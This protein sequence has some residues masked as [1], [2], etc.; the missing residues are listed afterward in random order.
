[1]SLVVGFRVR[2]ATVEDAA[3]NTAHRRA[4]FREMRPAGDAVLDEMAARFT[5]WVEEKLASEEY[6][7]WFAVAEYGA[8]AAGAGLWLMDWPAHV[9]G[10]GR[11]RGNIL[12]VYTEPGHRRLGLAR[13]LI[14]VAIEWCR[15]HD[16]DTVVLH[17]SDA[18]RPMYEALGFRATN[19]M[20]IVLG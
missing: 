12:N 15:E 8:I 18:G 14:E 20:R 13:H 17:A 2:R 19:E 3:V 4:M 7:A 5:P 10:K 11:W 16:V 9:V 1:M 6:L